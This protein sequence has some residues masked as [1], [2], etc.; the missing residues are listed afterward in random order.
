MQ[1]LSGLN[2]YCTQHQRDNYNVITATKQQQKN[3]KIKIID[4]DRAIV[5]LVKKSSTA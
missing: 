3:N 2:D 5:K 1:Q 4:K